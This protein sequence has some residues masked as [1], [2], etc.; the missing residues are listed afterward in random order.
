MYSLKNLVKSSHTINAENYHKGMKKIQRKKVFHMLR[1]YIY[2]P[3]LTK[4]SIKIM[5]NPLEHGI[6][7]TAVFD[8]QQV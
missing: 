3:F 7:P 4:I 6:K 1:S 2:L 5:V 8:Q